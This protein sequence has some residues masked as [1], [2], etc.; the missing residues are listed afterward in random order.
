MSQMK[1]RD[2]Q[3]RRPEAEQD[4][5]QQGAPVVGRLGVDDDVLLVQQLRELAACR[6]SVGTS[7][8]KRV[9]LDGVVLAGGRE[10]RR[11]LELALDRLASEEIS[12]TLPARTWSRKNGS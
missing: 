9:D 4:R 7:V 6:R 10:A 11:A 5:R 2:E 3:D 8:S 1:Q 12:R